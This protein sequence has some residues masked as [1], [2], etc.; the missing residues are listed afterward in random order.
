MAVA[1][2]AARDPL[3]L[4]LGLWLALALAVAGRTLFRPESHAVF[5]VFATAAAHWWDDQPLYADYAPLDFFRY[6]PPFAVAMTPFYWLGPVVGGILWNWLSIAVYVAG[7]CQFQ[8]HVLPGWTRARS[9]A[10]LALG[11]VGAL[12]GLWNGQSNALAV[13]LLLLAAACLA[14]RRWWG[15][16]FLLAG[17]V[18]LKL[19]PVALASLLCALWPRRLGGRFALA[20]AVG[21]LLPFLTRSPEVVLG[22]YGEWVE[23]LVASS[24]GRWPGFRDG[25]TV[26]LVVRHL[27]VGGTEPFDV[28]AP[29]D[30]AWY[31]G[32]QILTAG[33]ALVW[34]LWQQRSAASDRS[35]VKCTL[36]IGSA[37]L[38]LFGP[39]TEHSTY[40]FLAPSLACAWL[41]RTAYPRGRWLITASMVLILVL[42][43]GSLTEPLLQLTPVPFAILPLGSALFVAWLIG[44]A[45][46]P[47]PV[48][49]PEDDPGES[50]RQLTRVETWRFP[51]AEPRPRSSAQPRV[52]AADE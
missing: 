16:A 1:T 29:I 39:A 40:V 50:P 36:A 38:L 27:A 37:W 2:G 32:I 6:P 5:P 10:F 52:L 51:N 25:W 45:R 46:A 9:A 48:L 21:F 42:G 23:H 33:L 49:R 8:R 35:L 15:A 13:G 18:W 17:A 3:R 14:R 11:A 19:T 30:T 41:E 4:A 7:L 26:W 24:S 28:R 20:L 12:R 47:E 44:N 34:C 22:Y 31:R 43:W